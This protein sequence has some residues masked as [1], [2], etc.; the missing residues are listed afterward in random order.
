MAGPRRPARAPRFPKRIIN[1]A[2]APYPLAFRAIGGPSRKALSSS[3]VSRS[4]HR[5]ASFSFFAFAE[6]EL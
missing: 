4:P 2:R 6:S 5:A 3:D 1:K